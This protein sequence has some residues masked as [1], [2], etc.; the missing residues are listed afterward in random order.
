MDG[1]YHPV[2]VYPLSGAWKNLRTRAVYVDGHHFQ[3]QFICQLKAPLLKYPMCPV[4]GYVPLREILP[5]TRRLSKMILPAAWWQAPS[6]GWNGRRRYVLRSRMPCRQ[7]GFCAKALLHHPFEV[8]SQE[9]VY[10]E[11]VEGT[12]VIG[13]KHVGSTFMYFLPSMYLHRNKQYIADEL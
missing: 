2:A 5:V 11:Y 7:T 8:P 9:S 12:L 13:H 4:K 3:L 6:W 10:R 1:Q